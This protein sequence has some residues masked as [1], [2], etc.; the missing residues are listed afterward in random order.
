LW[1]AGL[2]HEEVPMLF[3]LL[4]AAIVPSDRTAQLAAAVGCG[5]YFVLTL[6][7]FTPVTPDSV[8]PQEVA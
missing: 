4:L 2:S 6:A 8:S 3:W 1:L 7:A 5:V